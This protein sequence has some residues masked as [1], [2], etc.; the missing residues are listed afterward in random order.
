[1]SSAEKSGSLVGI[2]VGVTA[3]ILVLLVIISAVIIYF[4]VCRKKESMNSKGQ[5]SNWATLTGLTLSLAPKSWGKRGAPGN[6]NLF[7]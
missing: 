7:L 2:A 4:R 1:M 5:L 3:G 6:A